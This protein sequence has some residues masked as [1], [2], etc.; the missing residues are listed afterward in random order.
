MHQV[1]GLLGDHGCLLNV[2][3]VKVGVR[4]I[5]EIGRPYRISLHTPEIVD[6]HSRTASMHGAFDG[7]G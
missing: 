5:G 4:G 7:N 6:G 2:K 3:R 1:P